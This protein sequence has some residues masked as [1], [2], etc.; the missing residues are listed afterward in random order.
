MENN[1]KTDQEK[2]IE[3]LR[4]KESREKQLILLKRLGLWG[5]ILI[6]LVGMVW[7]L[8]KF[9]APTSTN[10]TT[11]L[12]EPVSATDHTKGNLASKV[13]LVEYSDFQC[14]ACGQFY[15]VVKTVEQKYGKD[16]LLVYRHFPLPSHDKSDLAARA[17]EAASAQGKFWEMHDKLFDNQTTWTVAPEPEKIFADYA[18]QLG[19]NKEKFISDLKSIEVENRIQKDISSGSASGIQGTP[20]FFLNGKVLNLQTYGD[21]ETN[22][23]T[24]I[25]ENR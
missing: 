10:N 9:G 1:T 14:P 19:L 21:L 16:I 4:K 18:V 13:V 17:S 15:P 2:R 12:S 3:E 25:T 8:A 20:T 7:G 5:G 6:A 11:P 23:A 24:A 22:V